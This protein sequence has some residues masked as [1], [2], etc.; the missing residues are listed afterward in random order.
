LLCRAS[1]RRR[2]RGAFDLELK[3]GDVSW[4]VCRRLSTNL[5]PARPRL[6]DSERFIVNI[7]FDQNQMSCGQPSSSTECS[8]IGVHVAKC[9]ARAQGISPGPGRS[10]E[11]PSLT[12]AFGNLA[13]DRAANSSGGCP[14]VRGDSISG[15]AAASVR[16]WVVASSLSRALSQS[17]RA[18]LPGAF[19]VRR[20]CLRDSRRRA[21]SVG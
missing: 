9:S 1:R 11:E 21:C 5:I 2:H 8:V 18:A 20:P 12:Q 19:H 15:S 3:A 10:R 14:D 6:T 16:G 4:P 13:G 7:L 17:D